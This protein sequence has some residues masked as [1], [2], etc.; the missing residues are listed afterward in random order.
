M[1]RQQKAEFKAQRAQLKGQ[2]PR[3]WFARH[4]ILTVLLVIVAI[5]TIGGIAGGSK[6]GSS[7]SGSPSASSEVKV[8]G[9]ARDGKFEFVVGSVNCGRTTVGSEY[10]TK[11]AQGQF[12]L[13]DITVKNIGDVQQVFFEA[14]QKLL[15]SDGMQYSSDSVASLYNSNNTDTWLNPINPGNSIHGVIVFDIPAGQIPANAELHDSAFSS[16][17]KVSLN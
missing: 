10:L 15:S 12:C 13:M 2:D 16:G 14:N 6:K 8:G 17:V 7:S 4:K 11:K 5:I 1:N 9:A 3:N